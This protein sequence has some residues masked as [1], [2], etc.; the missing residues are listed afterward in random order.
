ML[1]RRY[2]EKKNIIEKKTTHRIYFLAIYATALGKKIKLLEGK[3]KLRINNA[4]FL[5]YLIMRH[6]H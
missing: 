4:E 5:S 1:R 2:A 6:R 3:I